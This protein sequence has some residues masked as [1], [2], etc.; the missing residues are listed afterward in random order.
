MSARK[1]RL[2]KS[3]KS[4]YD[5]LRDAENGPDRQTFGFKH[6]LEVI[7]ENLIELEP[8]IVSEFPELG[9]LEVLSDFESAYYHKG[10]S[11]MAQLLKSRIKKLAIDIDANL[12]QDYTITETTTTRRVKTSKKENESSNPIETLVKHNWTRGE[13]IGIASIGVGFLGIVLFFLF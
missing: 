10:D 2:R 4:I 11:G 9:E 8:K 12:E 13:K 6:R 7:H 3:L 1:T 5:D